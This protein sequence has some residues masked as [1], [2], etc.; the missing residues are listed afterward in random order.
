MPTIT[1]TTIIFL[2][3]EVVFIVIG[4]VLLTYSSKI[5]EISKQYDNTC[6]S[7]MS[8]EI[9]IEIKEKMVQPIMIYY[10]IDN[11]YQNHRRYVK[12]K[13]DKQLNGQYLDAKTIKASG[14]CDPVVTNKEMGK[15]KSLSGKDLNPG[16][17]AVPCGLIA[18]SLFDDKFELFN[19]NDTNNKSTQIEIDSKDIAWE[20]DKKLK[21]KNIQNP[22][23][24]K[25]WTDIQWTNIEDEHFIV[26]MRL[27]GLPNFRK[28]YGRVRQ[29]LQGF[30]SFKIDNNF[31]VSNFGGKKYIVIS[32]VNAFGGK[33]TFLGISYIIAG[34]VFILLA[35]VFLVGYHIHNRK[36][37]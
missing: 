29:D 10:Q 19:G 16:D 7:H 13:S 2:T 18:K 6:S 36:E 14:D 8:C 12:S 28:L 35:I 32:T 30:Y 22:P 37:K 27:A 3:F 17:V 23:K 5:V 31:E 26:W 20:A 1:S 24:G 25:N 34:V 21:Y 9:Q 33:N 15:T 4:A 11:F